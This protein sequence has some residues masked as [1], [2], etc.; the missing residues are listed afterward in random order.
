MAQERIPKPMNSI[1]QTGNWSNIFTGF[2]N[3]Y[4]AIQNHFAQFDYFIQNA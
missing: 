2:K 1:L 3:G 4:V